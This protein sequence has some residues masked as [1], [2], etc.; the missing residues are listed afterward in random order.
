MV[1][2]VRLLLVG[3]CGYVLLLL[4]LLSL[5]SLLLL[6]VDQVVHGDYRLLAIGLRSVL[7][8]ALITL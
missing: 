3:G 5:M 1:L 7:V 6:L 2:I 8:L 4:L